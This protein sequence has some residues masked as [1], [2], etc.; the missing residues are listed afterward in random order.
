[1][2]GLLT[3]KLG[4]PVS[5]P[6]NDS[7]LL[8][9]MSNLIFANND[10]RP[11]WKGPGYGTTD[12]EEFKAKVN[13]ANQHWALYYGFIKNDERENNLILDLG[14]G[15][16]FCTTN[17]SYLY[18]NASILG[19]DIDEE[20]IDFAKTVNPCSN[21]EYTA[22]DITDSILPTGVDTIFL[23]EIL[24]HIKHH[25]HF[26]FLDKCLASLKDDT[27]RI[28]LTTPNEQTYFEGDRGH[29]GILTTTLFTL[30]KERYQNNIVSVD[31]YD[32]TKLIDNEVED[33]IS[34]TPK[35]HYRVILKKN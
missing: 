6:I 20:V 32:N 19:Y 12:V 29:I 11:T 17:L 27:S 31:F 15:S 25:K 3:Y 24:E 8:E 35:S 21:V 18:P 22:E 14:C 10:V 28:Y 23:V 1:V 9:K 5:D 16:G 34:K 30:F 7:E 4:L 2:N 33:Y 13:W 26:D